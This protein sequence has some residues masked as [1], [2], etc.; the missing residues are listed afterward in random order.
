VSLKGLLTSVSINL[1][2][3]L[4]RIFDKAECDAQSGIHTGPFELRI[5]RRPGNEKQS[6]P[7]NLTSEQQMSSGDLERQELTREAT[8]ANVE[9]GV[10]PQATGR[11]APWIM[12]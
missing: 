4:K 5:P 9:G 6:L 12:S 3:N 10:P 2:N 8:G 11:L 1:E 7:H